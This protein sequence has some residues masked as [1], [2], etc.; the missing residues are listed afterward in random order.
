MQAS[1]VACHEPAGKL[2]QLCKVLY[3]FFKVFNIKRNAVYLLI[4]APYTH[5]VVFWYISNM[6]P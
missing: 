6:L 2:W 5:I 4:H 1:L 3:S